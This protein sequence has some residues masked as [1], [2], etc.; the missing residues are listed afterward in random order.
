MGARYAPIERALRPTP[1][2]IVCDVSSSSPAPPLVMARFATP[3]PEPPRTFF[4]PASIP[5]LPSSSGTPA[6]TAPQPT[7]LAATPNAVGMNTNAPSTSEKS[8]TNSVTD[9][10]TS[11]D[12]ESSDAK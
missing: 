4:N 2:V 11:M 3:Q 7:T 8:A 10:D 1:H 9:D 12:W 5:V 6:P